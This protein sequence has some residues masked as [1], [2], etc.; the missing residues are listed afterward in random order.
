MRDLLTED[1]VDQ[2]HIL[3]APKA[4]R[5]RMMCSL[6]GEHVWRDDDFDVPM[7]EID[8]SSYSTPT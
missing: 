8:S 2:S 5:M 4:N 3:C 1:E 6:E 7:M